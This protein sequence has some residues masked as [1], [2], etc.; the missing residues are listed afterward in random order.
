[1]PIDKP[2]GVKHV[3]G[4]FVARGVVRWEKHRLFE[5][6]NTIVHKMVGQLGMTQAVPIA[7]LVLAR[8]VEYIVL[9]DLD[10]MFQGI[11]VDHGLNGPWHIEIPDYGV[12]FNTARLSTAIR[13][14]VALERRQEG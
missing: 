8:S 2:V 3:Q 7:L 1:M 14:I 11:R 10:R 12:A 4:A 13:R 5:A 6:Y 9:H